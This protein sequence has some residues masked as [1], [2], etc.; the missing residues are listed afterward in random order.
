MP[1]LDQRLAATLPGPEPGKSDVVHW[2][3]RLRGFGLRVWASGKRLWIVR[4]RLGQRQRVVT[5]G[6]VG[7]ITA[8]AARKRAGGVL[9]AKRLGHDE[10]RSIEAR[11]TDALKVPERTLLDLIVA[12][13]EHVVAKQKPR[14]QAETRRHLEQHWRSLHRSPLSR[15][16][17]AAVAARLLELARASGPVA[18]NRARAALSAVF[19]WGMRAGLA[20]HNPVVGTVRHDEKPRERVLTEEELRLIWQATS[21]SGD[22][23]TIVRLLMLT[24]QR[25]EEVAALCWPEIKPESA[26]WT[27]P[28][29]RS[30][31]GRVHEVPLATQVLE[32][33]RAVPRRGGRNSSSATGSEASRGGRSRRPASTDGWPNWRATRSR[34]GCCTTCVARR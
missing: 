29:E 12:Y 27:L 23:N 8:A 22:H 14:T 16:D 4:Y 13:K 30:K 1:E 34:L 20:D 24:G 18:G 11:K 7:E 9:A 17:R 10:R 19:S 2:D 31:N 25:R 33:L 32:I 5:L 3:D 15:I 26:L 28:S 21:G 6:A